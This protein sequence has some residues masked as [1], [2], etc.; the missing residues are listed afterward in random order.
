MVII[1]VGLLFAVSFRVTKPGIGLAHRH[2]DVGKWLQ[3]AFRVKQRR[4]PSRATATDINLKDHSQRVFDKNG[5]SLHRT[6]II[7]DPSVEKESVVQERV[8]QCRRGL[9]HRVR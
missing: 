7:F 1:A 2:I 4:D 8:W 5:N 9:N 3:G 6:R